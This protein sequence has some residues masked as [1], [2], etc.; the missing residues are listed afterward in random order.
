[1]RQSLST[2]MVSKTKFFFASAGSLPHAVTMPDDTEAVALCAQLKV[3]VK[4][5]EDA[6]VQAAAARH[7]VQ[8]HCLGA[9]SY[10]CPSARAIFIFLVIFPGRGLAACP[11]HLFNLRRHG[12]RRTKPSGGR[13]AQRSPAGEHRP[14]FFLHQLRQLA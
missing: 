3:I 11:H 14:R 4:E 1:M 10:S 2:N 6:E 7:R 13:S 5:V 12:R 8:G 9:D